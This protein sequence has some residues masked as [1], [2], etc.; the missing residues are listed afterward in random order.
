[1]LCRADKGSAPH[2][3]I[4]LR[5]LAVDK[6][7]WKQAEQGDGPGVDGQKKLRP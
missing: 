7:P 2:G 4:R 3:F 6:H 5:S 1:M